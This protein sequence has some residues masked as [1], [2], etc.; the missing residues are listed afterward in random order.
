MNAATIVLVVVVL[1]VAI[2]LVLSSNADS[3]TA[4]SG[5]VIQRCGADGAC[6][7]G[8]TCQNGFCLGLPNS[9]CPIIGGCADGR[10]CG[11]VGNDKDAQT[12]CCPSGAVKFSYC[13][14]KFFC[15]DV[16]NKDETCRLDE[17]CKSKDCK[18]NFTCLEGKCS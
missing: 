17:Q 4:R 3:D 13:T 14:G 8:Y 11:I 15:T 9:P 12:V 10:Y 1:V 16:L 6:P 2:W 18:G 5:P 7:S